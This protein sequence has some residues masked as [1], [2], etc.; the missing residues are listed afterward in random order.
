MNFQQ[1][2]RIKETKDIKQW[3]KQWKIKTMEEIKTMR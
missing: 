3:I 2:N 1:G